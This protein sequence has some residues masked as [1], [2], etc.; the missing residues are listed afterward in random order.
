MFS[1]IRKKL[2]FM[3]REK[4]A[5]AMWKQIFQIQKYDLVL[6]SW[7]EILTLREK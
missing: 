1:Y 6:E 4:N 3:E 5:E 2:Q 7:N